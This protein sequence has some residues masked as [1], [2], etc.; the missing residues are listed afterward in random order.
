M[1]SAI[2]PD[3]PNTGKNRTLDTF[4]KEL[5]DE[6]WFVPERHDDPTLLRFLRAR[7]WDIQ[8][9]KQM[10]LEAERWRK[11]FGVDNILT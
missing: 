3:E 7:K 11:E 4:R 10:I 1:V 2:N 8:M 6:G 9:A 5:Q